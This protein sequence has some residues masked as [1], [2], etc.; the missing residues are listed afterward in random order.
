VSIGNNPPKDQRSAW[1]S[2]HPKKPIL[3]LAWT[4]FDTFGLSD[5]NCH[6][7]LQYSIS[8]N[9]GSKWSKPVQVNQTPGDCTGGDNAIE[10]GMV[11]VGLDGRI[12]LT[13]ANQGIIFFDRSY[14]GGEMWLSNDIA[15]AKQYS[16]WSMKVPGYKSVS[17]RPVLVMDNSTSRA[18]GSLYVTYADQVNGEEDTDIWLLRSTNKGDVWTK[19]VRINADKPG[20]HQ[21]MPWMTVDQVTGNIY[22]VY[23]SRGAYTDNQTD[24]YMAYSWDGGNTFKEVKLS[25]TPFV[26]TE[27]ATSN[28]QINIAAYDGVIV[29]VWTRMDNGKSSVWT[30]II[31]DEVLLRK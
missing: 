30:T 16:G 31:K 22:V 6:S 24:V 8:T 1:P 19:P 17:G 23:Y 13:W 20:T 2:V 21:Y 12:Y 15:I 18:H 14:D 27:T 4:Q 10:G 5:A 11:A 3:Y 26:P 25:E 9:A 28:Q 29:P 7:N